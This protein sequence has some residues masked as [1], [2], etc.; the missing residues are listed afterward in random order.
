MTTRTAFAAS[1]VATACAAATAR[2]DIVH[3]VNPAPGQ[4]GHYDW[5]WE[6]V[7]GWQNWLDITAGPSQQTDAPNGNSVSQSLP[8]GFFDGNHHHA[9]TPDNGAF[10][11]ADGPWF[12][13]TIPFPHGFLLVGGANDQD[14][15]TTSIHGGSGGHSYFPVDEPRYIGVL[16]QTGHHGWIEVVRAGLFT[17]SLTALSWAYE[18]VPGVPVFAGQIPTPGAA[19]LTVAGALGVVARRRRS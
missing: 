19:V 18:T 16:T 13:W 10:V 12:Q 4:P 14:W 17:T 9:E 7:T 6:N 5:R 1:L 2:A 8:I 3:F 11:L 15:T